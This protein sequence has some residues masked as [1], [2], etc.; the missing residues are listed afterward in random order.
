M[1]LSLWRNVWQSQGEVIPSLQMEPEGWVAKHSFNVAEEAVGLGST[2]L[3][4]A[5]ENV[6]YSLSNSDVV[7]FWTCNIFYPL[8][9]VWFIDRCFPAMSNCTHKN[10]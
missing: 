5:V 4:L 2:C 9:W 8:G 10:F 7:F 6:A 1:F 3:V